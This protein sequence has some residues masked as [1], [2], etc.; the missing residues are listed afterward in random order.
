MKNFCAKCL[1]ECDNM[2]DSCQQPY[3]SVSCLDSHHS[4]KLVDCAAMLPRIGERSE[5]VVKTSETEIVIKKLLGEGAWGKVYAACYNSNCETVVKLQ[6]LSS[7]NSENFAHPEQFANEI[8]ITRLASEKGFGPTTFFTE[9]FAR[10]NI[11]SPSNS[12]SGRVKGW[13]RR[14]NKS[15][16]TVGVIVQE[17][18][19]GSLDNLEAE[20]WRNTEDVLAQRNLTTIQRVLTYKLNT[21]W[22]YGFTHADLLAKNV[23]YRLNNEGEI[24]DVTPADFGLSFRVWQKTDAFMQMLYEYFSDAGQ[25][26]YSGLQ[27]PRLMDNF[28]FDTVKAFPPILDYVM[29]DF[30]EAIRNGVD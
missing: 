25:R 5:V 21:M 24:T 27:A 3:C 29:L 9:I 10:Q 28:T 16:D 15:V 22:L 13:L 4:E 6:A 14:L 2:C 12:S 8:Q 11:P 18:W 23:L 1:N 17:R 30:L 20:H 7:T 19:D 26:E